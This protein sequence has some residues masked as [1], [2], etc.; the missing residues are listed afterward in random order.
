[1]TWISGGV[2]RA[3]IAYPGLYNLIWARRTTSSD[4]ALIEGRQM[5]RHLLLGVGLSNTPAKNLVHG[6][7]CD[8]LERKRLTFRPLLDRQLHCGIEPLLARNF[9][10]SMCHNASLLI[11]FST[12]ARVARDRSRRQP[13]N[14]TW[15]ISARETSPTT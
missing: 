13:R 10:V 6:L 14:F 8:L 1:M 12:S 4:D 2:R 15:R 5:T 3:R 9:D 11:E 7:Y